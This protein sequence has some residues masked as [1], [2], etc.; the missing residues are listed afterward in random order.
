MG[1]MGSGKSFLGK[2]LAKTLNYNYIDLDEFIEESEGKSIHEIFN[3]KGEIY[4]R[5]KETQ[6]LKQ[7]IDSD[8]ASIIALGGGTPCYG[9]N[10][11]LIKNNE[12]I[13]SIYLKASLKTLV[14]RLA[15]E[16]QKRPLISHLKSK[17]LI[18]EFIGKHLFERTYY[19][20]QATITIN[21]DSKS[22]QDLIESIVLHL[23]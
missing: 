10:L 2:K 11:S 13:I 12:D 1:Y 3:T 17:D 15:P 20:E 18:L 7:L 14:D 21:V 9:S 5:K 23:I 19:Y 8:E 22:R 4:F 6:Y 16:K